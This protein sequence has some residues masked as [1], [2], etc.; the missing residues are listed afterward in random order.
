MILVN[1]LERAELFHISQDIREQ[2]VLAL[3]DLV[4]LVASVATHFHKALRGLSSA[5]VSINI[6]ATFRIQIENFRGRCDKITESM[7]K[8]QFAKDDLDL[9]R[10][11]FFV[12]AFECITSNAS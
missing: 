6:H 8:H 1:I 5:P 10:G 2:L 3:G 9:S 4:V 11:R 12:S 7:W